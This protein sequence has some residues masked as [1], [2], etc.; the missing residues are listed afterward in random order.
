MTLILSLAKW[1]FKGIKAFLQTLS[2]SLSIM[3]EHE[4]LPLQGTLQILMRIRRVIQWLAHLLPSER[5]KF[6]LWTSNFERRTVAYTLLNNSGLVILFDRFQ[7]P[8]LNYQFKQPIRRIPS[9][10]PENACFQVWL[11]RP[12]YR[13]AG[14]PGFLFWVRFAKLIAKSPDLSRRWIKAHQFINY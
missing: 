5:L 2:L 10:V 14:N 4:R 1:I 11:P 6:K 3:L 13:T 12:G 8:A 7:L 9:C